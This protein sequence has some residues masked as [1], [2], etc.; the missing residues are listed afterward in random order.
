AERP[1]AAEALAEILHE[2]LRPL[3][4]LQAHRD[5]ERRRDQ[6]A[7]DAAIDEFAGNREE[8][9]QADER[10]DHAVAAHA[11]LLHERRAIA[12]AARDFGEVAGGELERDL[13]FSLLALRW[14]ARIVACMNASK[15]PS[16]RECQGTMSLRKVRID[17]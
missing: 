3:L 12:R 7:R 15:R 11:P 17:S 5:E 13:H 6:R 10:A 14:A 8:G 9:E 4:R 2:P 16:A 1:V